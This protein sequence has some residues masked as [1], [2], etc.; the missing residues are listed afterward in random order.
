M[1]RR[2]VGR[3]LG[4]VAVASALLFLLGPHPADARKHRAR[5]GTAAPGQT[6]AAVPTTTLHTSSSANRFEPLATI[7]RPSSGAASRT[8]TAKTRPSTTARPAPPSLASNRADPGLA[9]IGFRTQQKLHDHFDK[10]GAEF[11]TMTEASYLQMA[12]ALRDAPL[13]NRVLEAVQ[14]DGTISRFDRK[15]GAF[16]AFDTDLTIRTFF[17]PDDGEAYFRRA[18]KRSH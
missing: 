4:L 3:A 8:A 7:K 11:G 6:T 13:S 14:A 15:T 1:A 12:Q 10:H 18:A 17:R 2:H 16:M 5:T 9:R